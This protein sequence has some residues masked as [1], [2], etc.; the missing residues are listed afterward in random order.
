[1]KD[2]A[3][4]VHSDISEKKSVKE[5]FAERIDSSNPFYLTPVFTVIEDSNTR[6]QNQFFLMERNN[7]GSAKVIFFAKFFF[8]F[9]KIL[10]FLM[11]SMKKKKVWKWTKKSLRKWIS[12]TMPD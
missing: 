1:M 4:G 5:Y 8:S 7:E 9:G 3:S 11:I 12:L 10:I 2:S 6:V